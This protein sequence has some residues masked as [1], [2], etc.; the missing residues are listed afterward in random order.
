MIFTPYYH[1]IRHALSETFRRFP[2]S[3]LCSLAFCIISIMYNQI[4]NSTIY[5]ATLFC[6]WCWFVAIKLFW[7]SQCYRRR[8]SYLVA[9]P[10]FL[11]LGYYIRSEIILNVNIMVLGIGL[12]LIIF[13]AP[14]FNKFRNNLQFWLFSYRLWCRIAYGLF[15][16]LILFLGVAAVLSCLEYLFSLRLFKNQYT[17]F[18]I[19][20]FTF[21]FP[22]L[23]LTGIDS[24]FDTEPEEEMAKPVYYLLEYLVVPLI[25]IYSLILYAY[26]VK[27]AIT[28]ALPQGKVA[29]L[30]SSYGCVGILTYLA[31][32]PIEPTRGRY[33]KIFREH[34]FKIL[35][36]PTILLAVGIAYRFQQYG[37]TES[38]YVLALCLVWFVLVILFFF[39]VR[40]QLFAKAI[41]IPLPLL[42]LLASF[43]P[44][45]VSDLPAIE[46]SR[47]LHK[48][49]ADNHIIQ[50]GLIISGSHK[51]NVK[52]RESISG[53]LDYL[54]KCKKT[55]V[56]AYWFND[57][58]SQKILTSKEHINPE[59]IASMIG[60][61]YVNRN[62][63]SDR[64]TSFSYDMR[65][66]DY[67]NTTNY[68]Y[69]I[70]FLYLSV[71]DD[72]Q[73]VITREIKI[74]ELGQSIIVS[75]DKTLNTLTIKKG[76][77]LLITII[78]SDLLEKLQSASK[79]EIQKKGVGVFHG[80][81]DVSAQL[82]FWN[83][84]GKTIQKT[85][86]AKVEG[87]QFGL[88]FGNRKPETGK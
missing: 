33:F 57:V 79:E 88:L 75:F 77:D 38:R 72:R 11:I 73:E 21:F 76:K 56:L 50:D 64:D 3:I 29:Y 62:Q 2:F 87:L 40:P 59:K 7:E 20:S 52:D 23:L 47:R 83:I 80:N 8:Y 42:L 68:D 37:L 82:I 60:I 26:M 67:L 5:L 4:G 84:S 78:L 69:C 39:V 53:I 48:I 12:F 85:N 18:W 65:K 49:L 86:K 31:G 10:V 54:V 27:I 28:R 6:G 16:A 44:W 22:V 13:C 32:I 70:P 25:F 71:F 51:V 9:I 63:R 34:F 35:I 41:Y 14:F 36:F 30:V 43:G 61:Q 74:S 46:Q 66:E 81:G 19:I 1:R 45:S 58:Q 55:D 15:A 17:D 24:S